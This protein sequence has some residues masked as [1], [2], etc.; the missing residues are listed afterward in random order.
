MKRTLSAAL[1]V[2]SGCFLS[3]EE[4]NVLPTVKWNVVKAGGA[5]GSVEKAGDGTVRL[6]R[7]GNQGSFWFYNGGHEYPV[8][9]GKVYRIAAVYKSGVDGT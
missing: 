4:K 7:T 9:P 2:L 5:G 6:T 3:A 8:K 1:L